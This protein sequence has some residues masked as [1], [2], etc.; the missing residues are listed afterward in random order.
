[1]KRR[2]IGFV[3]L[4]A[5]LI[6][7]ITS[8]MPR[9][10]ASEEDCISYE[11]EGYSVCYDIIDSW[12]DM[13]KVSVSIQNTGSDDIE[14]WMLYFDPK[15]EITDIWN[16]EKAITTNNTGY[17]RNS[18]FNSVIRTGESTE[19]GYIV[20][21]EEEIPDTFI[22]CQTRIG[23]EE[24]Y[25][26]DL[27]EINSWED[28]RFQ[29]EIIIRNESA[30]P[31]EAWKLSI[32]TNFTIEQITNSWAAEITDSGDGKYE[33]K[34]T[35]NSVIQPYS[36]VVLGFLGV[37][38]GTPEIYSYSLSEVKANEELLMSLI[39]ESFEEDPEAEISMYASGEVNDN[40]LSVSWI[41]D[42]EISGMEYKVIEINGDNI[43]AIS[44]TQE[45]G[46]VYELSD[47]FSEKRVYIEAYYNGNYAGK[48]NEF[49]VKNTNGVFSSERADADNDNISDYIEELI[50]TDINKKD[51]DE[52]GLDD[53][54]EFLVLETDPL[55][56]DTDDNGICDGDEDSDS[57]GLTNSEEIRYGVNPV[58]NDTD[59]DKLSDYEEL[60]TYNTDPNLEDTDGDTISDYDEVMLGINPNNASD[61]DTVVEQKIEKDSECFSG[62]NVEGL[63]YKVSMNIKATGYVAGSLTVDNSDAYASTYSFD[64]IGEIPEFV[65]DG[66]EVKEVTLNFELE[67]EFVKENNVN[68]ESLNVFKYFDEVNMFVPVKTYRDSVNNIISC[69]SDSLGTFCVKD[70]DEWMLNFA[71]PESE[72]NEQSS[73]L[74]TSNVAYASNQRNVTTLENGGNQIGSEPVYVCFALDLTFT[75]NISLNEI[76]LMKK[77]IENIS[78]KLLANYKNIK[79]VILVYTQRN[80]DVRS[81]DNISDIKSFLDQCYYINNQYNA[82]VETPLDFFSTSSAALMDYGYPDLSY[83]NSSIKYCFIYNRSIINM[84]SKN[85]TNRMTIESHLQNEKNIHVSFVSPALSNA[86]N[87]DY[88]SYYA[89]RY[90]GQM[91]VLENNNLDEQMYSLIS[92][93]PKLKKKS[94][95]IS[96]GTDDPSVDEPVNTKPSNRYILSSNLDHVTLAAPLSKDSKIDTDKD[97]LTDIEELIPNCRLVKWDDEGNIILP[98]VF[99]IIREYSGDSDYIVQYGLSNRFLKVLPVRSNPI[100]EDTDYDGLS[101]YE[102]IIEHSTN[103]LKYN[104]IV[105]IQD[106]D[107]LTEDSRYAATA[108]KSQYEGDAWESELAVFIANN[109][110][111]S[112]HDYK[113]VY[114]E[115]LL[116]YL[117][118]INDYNIINNDRDGISIEDE[119]KCLYWVNIFTQIEAVIS[120]TLKIHGLDYENINSVYYYMLHDLEKCE[121]SFDDNLLNYYKGSIT[122]QFFYDE[123]YRI[124]DSAL[125]N[126]TFR[127]CC[128]LKL[129]GTC[130]KF[131][132]KANTF[133]T[134]ASIAESSVVSI[135][136]FFNDTVSIVRCGLLIEDDI[137]FLCILEYSSNSLFLRQAAKELKTEIENKSLSFFTELRN[138]STMVSNSVGDGTVR[139]TIANCSGAGTLI[140]AEIAITD[141]IF[142]VSSVGLNFLMS[143]TYAEIS[144][145]N[146]SLIKNESLKLEISGTIYEHVTI[147]EYFIYGSE[148]A[149]QYIYSIKNLCTSRIL[150]EESII[151]MNHWNTRWWVKIMGN[152]NFF[153]NVQ[154][155]IDYVKSISK[156]YEKRGTI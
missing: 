94:S 98:T 148:E 154:G 131:I 20:K 129:F 97:E 67:N 88:L 80:A 109:I 51:T 102:E 52:D 6:T 143:Y 152:E 106:V 16:A 116:N 56:I 47:D 114:K 120:K 43:S 40:E 53:Y 119:Q 121:K 28:V 26:V 87:E 42:K 128:N 85:E 79:I 118:E 8:V 111:G 91:F 71:E 36:E 17:L 133:V 144:R 66:G 147:G 145:V 19:F 126:E 32:D 112:T 12:D 60:F 90:K 82:Y 58:N 75:Q 46:Y 137:E 77:S 125:N 45:M 48:S 117:N 62:I 9:V 149:N 113:I 34:G 124:I 68:I 138:L 72:D 86:S 69:Q 21:N 110:F 61:S 27:K 153:N 59:N 108:L 74:L 70:V 93:E 2:I 95:Y 38:N 101:D 76:D 127:K 134:I 100:K 135:N 156:K 5:F 55:K 4:A 139:M 92:K 1:M 50:G 89:N 31:I 150:G 105:S 29:G 37:K 15:G 103:P 104:K 44:S 7:N 41:P 35:Y 122:K 107:V 142:S 130:V 24:G 140:I 136:E 155:N 146:S 64:T 96:P 39:T 57:D 65:Y 11:Y 73:F 151:A 63:P 18:G 99:D 3:T 33:L 13:Q 115:T 132:D 30:E 123:N 141:L 49:I 10:S 14:N 25:S 81:F 84:L 83:D 78:Q 23:K 54:L 22:L